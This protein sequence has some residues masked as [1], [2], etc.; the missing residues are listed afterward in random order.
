MKYDYVQDVNTGVVYE[1]VLIENNGTT[2]RATV[3]KDDWRRPE[4]WT[5]KI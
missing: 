2:T 4:E 5:Q 1:W 3:F